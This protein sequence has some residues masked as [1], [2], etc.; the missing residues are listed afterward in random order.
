MKSAPESS[1]LTSTPPWSGLKRLLASPSDPFLDSTVHTHPAVPNGL[2][3]RYFRAP[4]VATNIF[5]FEVRR[6]GHSR[7]AS[8]RTLL[9]HTLT[10]LFFR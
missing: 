1:D 9:L 8:I 3:S 5:A 10:I 2:Y 6:D 7:A 4:T